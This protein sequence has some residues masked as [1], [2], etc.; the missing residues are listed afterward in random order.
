[1]MLFFTPPKNERNS[2]KFELLNFVLSI[3]AW[4]LIPLLLFYLIFVGLEAAHFPNY[5]L[6][7]FHF[8]LDG[9]IGLVLFNLSLFIVEKSKS[10]LPEKKTKITLFTYLAI[11][12]LTVY[13]AVGSSMLSV[14]TALIE[15][16]YI[17][18]HPRS[19]YDEKMYY[20]WGDFY[21]FMTFVSNNTPEDAT[22]VI[23]PRRLPWYSRTGDMGL[24]RSFLFPRKLLEYTS[25]NIPDV[26][27]LPRGTYVLI[28]WGEA[29]CNI[30]DCYGW[31]KQP[32]Q[33]NRIIYKDPDSSAAIEI[34]ENSIY[35]HGDSKYVY[36]LIK[37]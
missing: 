17:F 34:K 19:S 22:I 18:L 24:V 26:G 11:I 29:E 31:P 15:D 9:L 12:A 3:N 8:H 28:S 6:A 5:V 36:G 30:P 21:R 2:N 10:S 13:F 23:P 4:L 32:I 25:E 33:A 1:M 7:H 16:F 35:N 14:N 20:R 37:L 27:S